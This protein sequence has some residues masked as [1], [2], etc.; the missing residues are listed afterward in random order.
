[1]FREK[2]VLKNFAKFTGQQLCQSLFFN[3]IAGLRPE[4][5]SKKRLSHKCF[6]VNFAKLLR[7]PFFVEQW[8]LLNL[9]HENII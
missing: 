8:L 4:N 5:L 3:K 1:M 6:P 9:R 7:A 2:D